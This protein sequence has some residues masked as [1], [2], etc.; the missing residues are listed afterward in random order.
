MGSDILKNL[1]NRDRIT[2]RIENFCLFCKVKFFNYNSYRSREEKP[3]EFCG[4][5]CADCRNGNTGDILLK[6]YLRYCE[7][8]RRKYDPEYKKRRK[9]GNK[10]NH[11][12]RMANKAKRR[13]QKINA[14]PSWVDHKTIQEIY[15]NCP[16]DHHVDH[17]IP[18][19]NENVCGL[20]VPWNLQY[21][22][23]EQNLVK[24]NSYWLDPKNPLNRSI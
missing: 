18:L 6:K 9:I 24:S 16:P 12:N 19:I 22:T 5:F 15:K 8:L 1:V 20:H 3:L 11:A 4:D 2:Y 7:S 14:S 10:K 21:L 13:A 23:A 17:I